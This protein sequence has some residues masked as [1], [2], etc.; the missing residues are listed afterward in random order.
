MTD[1]IE[2]WLTAEDMQRLWR[3][4]MEDAPEVLASESELREFAR[5]VELAGYKKWGIF[6]APEALQ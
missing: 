4:V 2:T 3:V 1:T 5:V 6:P